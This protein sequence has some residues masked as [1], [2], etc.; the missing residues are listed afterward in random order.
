VVTRAFASHVHLGRLGSPEESGSRCATQ[1]LSASA[2]QVQLTSEAELNGS[3]P[4]PL[5]SRRSKGRVAVQ[6][7]ENAAR[8]GRIEVLR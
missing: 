6:V 5:I 1:G 4:D 8:S 2:M 7:T 3:S